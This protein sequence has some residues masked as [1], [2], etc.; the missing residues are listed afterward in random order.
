MAGGG[1][2]AGDDFFGSGIAEEITEQDD[3]SFHERAVGIAMEVTAPVLVFRE[4]PDLRNTAGHAVGVD[5]LVGGKRRVMFGA[6]HHDGEAFLRVFDDVEVVEELLLAISHV[7]KLTT[8]AH[9][10]TRMLSMLF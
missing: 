1:E 2:V 4:E 6:I 9:E 8:N 7:R 5:A 3:E 10:S